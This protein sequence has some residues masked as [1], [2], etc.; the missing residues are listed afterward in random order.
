MLLRK[1]VNFIERPIT[2]CRQANIELAVIIE[3][4]LNVC[5]NV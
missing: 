1:M 4:T 3:H 2:V 5:V